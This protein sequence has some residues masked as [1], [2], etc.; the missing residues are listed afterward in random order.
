MGVIRSREWLAC[1]CSRV[2][3][4]GTLYYMEDTTDGRRHIHRL[5][6]EYMDQGNLPTARSNR[7][8]VPLLL[9]RPPAADPQINGTYSL[10]QI[11]RSCATVRQLLKLEACW[12][13]IITRQRPRQDSIREKTEVCIIILSFDI[14]VIYTNL[15]QHSADCAMEYYLFRTFL[16]LI[17]SVGE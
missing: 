8:H 4:V 3:A 10:K 2:R 5:N 15:S 7:I 14:L 11:P 9:E 17:A 1:E 13:K 16:V 12:A 6:L